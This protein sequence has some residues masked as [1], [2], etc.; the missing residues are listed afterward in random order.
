MGVEQ[1][2]EREA[3]V[4]SHE[5]ESASVVELEPGVL[6]ALAAYCNY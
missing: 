1:A 2:R 3:T 6:R 4:I 5:S